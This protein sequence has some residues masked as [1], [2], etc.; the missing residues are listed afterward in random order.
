MEFLSLSLTQ[1]PPG[2]HKQTG[3]SWCTRHPFF[4]FFFLLTLGSNVSGTAGLGPA[5][6]VPRDA[7]NLRAA[8]RIKWLMV[9]SLPPEKGNK[10]AFR[11]RSLAALY[12]G[13]GF[14]GVS[15]H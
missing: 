5:G 1:S 15:S 14:W 7:G 4:R 13:P 9:K 3:D 11:A 6:E 12:S 8:F 10:V 2:R